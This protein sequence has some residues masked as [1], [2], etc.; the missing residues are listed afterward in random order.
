MGLQENFST[1]VYLK[2]F[3]LFLVADSDYTKRF[4]FRIIGSQTTV[5]IK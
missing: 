3:F 1:N 2:N 5:G 4:F